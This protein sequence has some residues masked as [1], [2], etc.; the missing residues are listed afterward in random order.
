MNPTHTHHDCC[1]YIIQFIIEKVK[2][3]CL[4]WCIQEKLLS[5]DLIS[6]C[7]ELVKNVE[8]SL[9]WRTL[10]NPILLQQICLKQHQVI[11]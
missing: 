4:H 11:T 1:T 7:Y 2:V 5:E 10:G 6:S 3:I 9:T 8:A